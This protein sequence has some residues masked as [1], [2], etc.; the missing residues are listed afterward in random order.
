[1]ELLLERLVGHL[2][3]LA[4]YLGAGAPEPGQ[5]LDITR[6]GLSWCVAAIFGLYGLLLAS[7][8]HRTV[9]PPT[10]GAAG[11]RWRRIAPIA[12]VFVAY[13][14]V[15]HIDQADAAAWWRVLLPGWCSDSTSA[16]SSA[17]RWA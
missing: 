8:A 7:W 12:M 3:F 16:R 5:S 2:T 13:S 9:Q 14:L 4:V 11:G 17:G 15:D 6:R 10:T 1:M